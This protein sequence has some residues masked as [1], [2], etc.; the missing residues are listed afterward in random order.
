MGDEHEV[1]TETE[2]VIVGDPGRRKAV[3]RD[4]IDAYN[5]RDETGEADARAPG[6]L[7]YAPGEPA[8]M[9]D[10]AWTEFIGGFV[11]GMPD[12]KIT[13][14]DIT[15]EG[16]LVTA[17]NTFTG[18]HTRQWQGLPPTHKQISFSGLEFN[19][20]V[21]GKVVEHWFQIDQLS[22]FEQLGLVV[23]P[24]PR[25]LG[26][27][28]GHK[29]KGL[30]GRTAGNGSGAAVRAASSRNGGA[31]P[32]ELDF[33]PGMGMR[34]EISRT[35]AETSGELFESVNWLDPR[36]P[37]PPVHVH[38][39]AEESFEV[40]EGSLDV[41]ANGEWKPLGP[42]EKAAVPPGEPHTLGNRS[43]RPAK[44]ITRINP[45]GDSEAFFAH[46]HRLIHEGKIKRLPPGEPRSAIYAA[47]LFKRY[48]G[49]IQVTG[50]LDAV[51]GAL[52]L[53]GRTLRLEP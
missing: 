53:V 6:Y 9:R 44:V 37:G 32:R 45:A 30:L 49:E 47:M 27:I 50:P 43:D 29:L 23:I 14:E 18:T 11:E 19:R 35:S 51:F 7:A 3:V 39:N 52:N 22:L 2:A 42:G 33:H 48:Q 1:G 25:L 5:R 26:R 15:E 10:E 16:D 31:S 17:R 34:W 46:L 24:G 13:I 28:V 8:P 12:L 40:I 36:M 41:F 38:P 4:W 21:D 20:L